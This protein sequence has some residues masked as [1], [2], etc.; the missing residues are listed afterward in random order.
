[1]DGGVDD[2]LY[3]ITD[4][5]GNPNVFKV[6]QNSDDLWL[7][8][9]WDKPSNEWTS[10]NR[11]AF[12]QLSSFLPALFLRGVLFSNMATPTTEHFS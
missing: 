2:V 3:K 10:E 4:R 1:M 9:N 7:N 5:D 8:T 11:W 6:E 12:S